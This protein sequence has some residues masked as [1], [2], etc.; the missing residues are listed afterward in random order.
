VE[1]NKVDAYVKQVSKTTRLSPDI[2]F[3][4]IEAGWTLKE[5]SSGPV[6]WEAPLLLL[7]TEEDRGLG[8]FGRS[9]N[10]PTLVVL[11]DVES[12]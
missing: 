11:D 8:V 5:D 4:L 7:K 12:V 2:C 1:R 6:C 9:P 10:Y 3:A